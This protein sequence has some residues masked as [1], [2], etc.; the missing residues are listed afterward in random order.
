MSDSRSSL[1]SSP[2]LKGALDQLSKHIDEQNAKQ[3]A[4]ELRRQPPKDDNQPDFF[5]PCLYEVPLKDD[6]YL[7]DIAPFSLSKAK[8]TRT[9]VYELKDKSI[10]IDGSANYGMATA[11]DYDI[12]QHMISYLVEEAN[13]F[14]KSVTKG[15]PIDAP[16]REY[17]PHVYDILK[18]C[19]RGDGGLQYKHLEAALNRLDG[20]TV[21]YQPQS[22]K[23]ERKSS[24]FNLIDGWTII[25]KT[26]SGEI[27]HIR[28]GIPNWIYQGVMNMGQAPSVLTLNPDYF[29]LKGGSTRFLYRYARK[30]TGKG[31]STVSAEE[32]HQRSGSKRGLRK[33]QNRILT[34]LVNDDVGYILEYRVRL[35]KNRGRDLVTFTYDADKDK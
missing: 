2:R 31:E 10:Q 17:A 20:T 11:H 12:V 34:P 15:N 28:I 9:L 18:F 25:A 13:I 21:K 33:W 26:D 6:V 22:S 5:V 8:S 7:M 19:R 27:A 3:N 32:L 23:G 16:P 4:Q 29:L 24:S 1:N 35:W 30:V 14:K